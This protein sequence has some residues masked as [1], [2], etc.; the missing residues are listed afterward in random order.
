MKRLNTFPLKS[1]LE[2]WLDD[3]HM[4][5]PMFAGLIGVDRK[6]VYKILDGE[7]RLSLNTGVK[8][9]EVTHGEVTYLSLIDFHYRKNVPSGKWINGK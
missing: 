5:V 9:E 2:V 4:P 3:N 7:N 1:P 6:T 8:I